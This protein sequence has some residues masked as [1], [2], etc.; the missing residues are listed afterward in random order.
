M[1]KRDAIEVHPYAA[2]GALLAGE[3]D[4]RPPRFSRR[5]KRLRAAM[6]ARLALIAAGP[7]PVQARA[8]RIQRPPSQRRT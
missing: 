5:R 8:P 7:E 4:A 3:L 2:L 1:G 6:R